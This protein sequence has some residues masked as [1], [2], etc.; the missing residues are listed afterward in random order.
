M[1]LT[2]SSSGSDASSENA[3]CIGSLLAETGTEVQSIQRLM[4][5]ESMA[6]SCAFSRMVLEETK[7]PASF[8]P[9][10]KLIVSRRAAMQPPPIQATFYWSSNQLLL[11]PWRL[12]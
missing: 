12:R 11:E 7:R 9:V 1:S 3:F 4:P 8:P 2:T 10:S 6:R 5:I